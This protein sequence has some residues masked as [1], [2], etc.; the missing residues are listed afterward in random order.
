M[1]VLCAVKSVPVQRCQDIWAVP[2][3]QYVTK[4]SSV[5][6]ISGDA[7]FVPASR[8]EKDLHLKPLVPHSFL[9]APSFIIPFF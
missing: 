6:E 1:S 4:E 5:S 3:L 9:F 8:I 7:S 2:V